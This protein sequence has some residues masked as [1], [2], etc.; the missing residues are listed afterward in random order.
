MFKTKYRIVK[1]IYGFKSLQLRFWW[2]PFYWHHSYHSTIDEAKQYVAN[3]RSF[4][5]GTKED[6]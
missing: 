6:V 5:K 3:G 1:G 4:W 2:M